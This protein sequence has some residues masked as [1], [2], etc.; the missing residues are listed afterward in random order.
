MATRTIPVVVPSVARGILDTSVFAVVAVSLAVIL[1]AGGGLSLW[2]LAA[3]LTAA[4]ITG[5][6]LLEPVNRSWYRIGALVAG[7]GAAVSGAL[8]GYGFLELSGIVGAAVLIAFPLRVPTRIWLPSIV[9]GVATMVIITW[10]L[11]ALIVDGG[12][13][14][15]DESAYAL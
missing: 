1:G 14:G 4:G 9:F 2:A 5:F 12:P 15:H 3:G 7:I 8:G 10:V 13:F 6:L 11:V